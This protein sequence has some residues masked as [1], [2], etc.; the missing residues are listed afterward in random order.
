MYSLG[1]AHLLAGDVS[2]GQRLKFEAG[3]L[4][5]KINGKI[6]EVDDSEQGYEDI[7]PRD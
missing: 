4:R 6:H 7:I 3:Q 5:G 2:E 1:E